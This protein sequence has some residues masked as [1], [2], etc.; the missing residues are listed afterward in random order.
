MNDKPEIHLNLDTLEAEGESS[1]FAFVLGGKR[2]V[3][4]DPLDMEWREAS[5]AIN[6]MDSG[7]LETGFRLLLG[8]GYEDFAA[9]RL[10]LRDVRRLAARAGKHYEALL[11]NPGES[12]ASQA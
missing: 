9:Q 3:M 4:R 8:E 11:G 1:P 12:P 6:A 7:D 2:H 10:S 5:R